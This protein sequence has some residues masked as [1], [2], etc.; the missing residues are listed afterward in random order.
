MMLRFWLM[1]W[2]RTLSRAYTN[3]LSR[4]KQCVHIFLRIYYKLSRHSLRVAIIAS[5]MIQDRMWL[6]DST[7][8]G[9]SCGTRSMWSRWVTLNGYTSVARPRPGRLLV[10]VFLTPTPV[11]HRMLPAC[12]RRTAGPLYGERVAARRRPGAARVGMVV[13]QATLLGVR[14]FYR[15]PADRQALL[16]VTS[17]QEHA[18]RSIIARS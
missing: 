7:W 6:C 15:R 4:T 5:R 9:I 13:V 8:S 14:V 11:G 10:A 2:T 16:S 3:Q 1:L 12:R 17:K 18:R